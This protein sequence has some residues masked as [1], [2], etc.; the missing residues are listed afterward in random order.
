MTQQRRGT[1]AV[2][3]CSCSLNHSALMNTQ[4][5]AVDAPRAANR[6]N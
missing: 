1:R 5:T 4:E 2:D 3:D 6:R